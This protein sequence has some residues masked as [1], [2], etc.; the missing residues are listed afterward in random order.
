MSTLALPGVRRRDPPRGPDLRHPRGR[1]P[2]RMHTLSRKAS[3]PPAHVLDAMGERQGIDYRTASRRVRRARCPT[4]GRLVLRG[5]DADV[6]AGDVMVDPTPL[7]A[8]GEWVITLRGGVTYSLSTITSDRQELD[9][10]DQ[11]R[12]LVHPS[13]DSGVVV[14][15]GHECRPRRLLPQ[16]LNTTRMSTTLPPAPGDDAIPF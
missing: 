13:T 8:I 4:C 12:R 9:D 11:W 15:P 10:R 7:T 1:A 3:K 6:A 14:V 2:R 5:L 16:C